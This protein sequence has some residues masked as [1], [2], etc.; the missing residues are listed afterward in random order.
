MA[1]ADFWSVSAM[2]ECVGENIITSNN[3]SSEAGDVIENQWR[4]EAGVYVL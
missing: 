3:I 2:K 1:N 4:C